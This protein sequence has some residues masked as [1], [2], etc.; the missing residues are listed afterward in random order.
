MPARV[1]ERA[2]GGDPATSLGRLATSGAR[3]GL[4]VGPPWRQGRSRVGF[5]SGAV[6]ASVVGFGVAFGVGLGVGFGVVWA[7]PSGFPRR[8]P[9]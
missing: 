4:A 9:R 8:W 3:V 5:G 6:V 2:A 1:S 7:L